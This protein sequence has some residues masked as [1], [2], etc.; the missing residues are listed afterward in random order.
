MRRSKSSNFTHN[1]PIS[2]WVF[3][4]HFYLP[5]YVTLPWL[6]CMTMT[7]CISVFYY[8]RLRMD[9]NE[10][11][12]FSPNSTSADNSTES[13]IDCT[14]RFIDEIFVQLVFSLLYLIIFCIGVFGN[15]L[16]CYVVISKKDMHSVTNFFIL[17]LAFSDILMCLFAV[18][19]T[20][21]QSFTGKWI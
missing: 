8:R 17:N 19:F 14:Q 6:K 2:L 11:D 3:V 10:T 15:V 9:L 13:D 5:K 4:L 18:P 16:V 21:L 20:P 7:Q 1:N 12:R